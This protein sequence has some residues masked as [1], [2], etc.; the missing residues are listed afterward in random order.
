MRI[1]VHITAILVFVLMS[2]MTLCV[3]A[4]PKVTE[5]LE[6]GWL[7]DWYDTGKRVFEYPTENTTIETRYIPTETPGEWIYYPLGARTTTIVDEHG[8]K[9]EEKL[10]NYMSGDWT[11]VWEILFQNAYQDGRLAE[12]KYS[13]SVYASIGLWMFKDLYVYE[14]G[15]L[16]QIINQMYDPT[17]EVYRDSE[18]TVYHYN[19]D[20]ID[21][22][23]TKELWD[24]DSSTWQFG[25]D[26]EKHI[27]QYSGGKL[28]TEEILEWDEDEEDWKENRFGEYTYNADGSIGIVL[29]K[30]WSELDDMYYNGGR[31]IYSYGT[32]S[33][34]DDSSALPDA[35]R[36]SNYPN[37]F[38]PVTTIY[39][40]IP[41]PAEVRLDIFDIR[42]RKIRTLIT[43][44]YRGAGAHHIQ[45][46]G[47]DDAGLNL[48]SG[49]Y[50]YRL[51]TRGRIISNMCILMK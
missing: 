8:N 3:S 30:G 24:E 51:S 35:F 29:W 9:I 45:W 20:V 7:Y 11:I 28:A 1:K 23:T 16:V 17:D 22:F 33:V 50:I 13:G 32:T 34:A 10:E 39:F 5:I 38:N 31:L 21:Y 36:L 48:S 40:D 41:E 25:S 46:D 18:R 44:E 42:G 15:K 2:M 6:Q 12:V 43:E 27:H 49:V 47:L 37:P 19:G 26:S 4:Q 14:D